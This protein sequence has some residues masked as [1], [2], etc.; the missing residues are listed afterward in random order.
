MVR[1]DSGQE[2]KVGWHNRQSLRGYYIVARPR[3]GCGI[4]AVP[5]L[6]GRSQQDKD[7]EKSIPE[8][9][10][11]REQGSGPGLGVSLACSVNRKAVRRGVVDKEWAKEPLVPEAGQDQKRRCLKAIE[12]SANHNRVRQHN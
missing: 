8:R 2:K 9:E 5:S 12:R 1:G 10:R 11:E 3:W 7:T 6:T 4:Q